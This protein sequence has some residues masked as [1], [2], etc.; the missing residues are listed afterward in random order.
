MEGLKINQEQKKEIFY[1]VTILIVVF[2]ASFIIFS[3]VGLAP[4]GLQ[5]ATYLEDSDAPSGTLGYYLDSEIRPLSGGLQNIDPQSAEYKDYE[6][7]FYNY[8]TYTRPDKIVINK[9]GVNTI[10]NQPNSRSVSVLDS[11]L[12][13]GAVH[14]PGSGTVEGGNMFIFG[15]STG[16]QVVQNQAYKAFNNL[17]DLQY[18]DEISVFADGQEYIYKVTNVRLVDENN[19]EVRFDKGGRTLTLS[20]CNSFGAKQDRFVVEAEFSREG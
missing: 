13:T 19:A 5:I 2:I 7:S 14:Y 20:T 8:N 15:H 16:F 3:G 1:F 4:T 10:I 6:N 9:I 12:G 11:A 18:G 17:D